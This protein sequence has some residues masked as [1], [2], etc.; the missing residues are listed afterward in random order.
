VTDECFYDL[1]APPKLV[2]GLDVPGVGLA[3]GYEKHSIPQP[4]G[5]LAAMRALAQL[6]A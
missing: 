5:I 4:D 6:Q 3:W 1:L 2:A